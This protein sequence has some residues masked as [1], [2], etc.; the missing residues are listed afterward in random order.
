MAVLDFVL[1]HHSCLSRIY[2][3]SKKINT[4]MDFLLKGKLKEMLLYC[5]SESD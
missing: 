3:I 2:F 5:V 1:G 4:T